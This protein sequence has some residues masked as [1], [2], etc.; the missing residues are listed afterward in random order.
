MIRTDSH[1]HS[2]FSSDSD[3]SMES[4]VLGGIQAGLES[5]CFTE[6]LDPLFP[7]TEDHF[8]FLIDFDAYEKEF[9]RLKILYRDQIELLHGVELGVQPHIANECRAFVNK[10]GS[11]YDYIICSTHVIDDLDPYYGTYFAKYAT[12]KEAIDHYFHIMLEN[13]HMLEDAGLEHAYQSI[14]HLDYICRYE[15]GERTP[16]FYDNHRD[17]I[18]P[19]LRYIVDHDKALEVNTAGWKY[20]ME[21]PNP[22][23]QIL[24]R[25][26]ELGGKKITIG[27]D[28]H[29]PEHLAYDFNRLPAFLKEIGFDSYL[30]Y[31]NKEENIILL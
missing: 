11:R 8:D 9:Q 18:D 22:N 30:Y 7:D 14:G 16:F 25:Y 19:I 15:P 6:H 27:S 21:D 31:R 2:S 1:L 26:V 10:Y 12:A 23:R 5:M 3:S 24:A 29:K 20:G 17:S 4:M 13:L 28:G